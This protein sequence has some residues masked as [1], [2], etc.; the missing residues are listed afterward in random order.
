VYEVESNRVFVIRGF[1]GFHFDDPD[2]K[3]FVPDRIEE[4]ICRGELTPTEGRQ[5][6]AFASS[7]CRG[8][9]AERAGRI[10]GYG[11]I[12][13][14]GEY[15]FGHGGKLSL[16]ENAAV[17]RNLFV[18]AE[19]REQGIGKKLN[20]ARLAAIP[21]GWLPIVFIIPENRYAITNWAR[22]G[23][24]PVLLVKRIIWLRKPRRT[25]CFRLSHDRIADDL[26]GCIF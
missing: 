19:F 9:L 17:L 5:L 1:G 4:G 14:T 10:A 12:Q 6:L 13:F 3:A 18:K 23:F 16:P 22:Y 2:V 25:R 11:W 15:E 26:M 24:A 7:G 21:A 20:A 8:F